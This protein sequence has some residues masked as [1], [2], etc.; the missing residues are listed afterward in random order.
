M[1]FGGGS[2]R[3]CSVS[4]PETKR[5]RTGYPPTGI[6]MAG[7]LVLQP[8]QRVWSKAGRIVSLMALPWGLLVMALAT[9]IW[10]SIA[11]HTVLRLGLVAVALTPAALWFV[12]GFMQRRGM[13][14]FFMRAQPEIRLHHDAIELALGDGEQRRWLPWS[15]IGSLGV[16]WPQLGGTPLCDETGHTIVVIPH[17]LFYLKDPSGANTTLAQEVVRWRP[18]RYMF[19]EASW[20]PM[21][22][23]FQ[24]RGSTTRPS[25]V[26]DDATRSMRLRLTALAVAVLFAVLSFVVWLLRP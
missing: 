26:A 12:G 1:D 6:P 2:P 22:W 10:S 23:G 15:R 8:R 16:T 14:W 13:D 24:L 18:D 11:P 7:G 25:K 9:P 4:R 19:D 3:R 20:V 21:S 17:F 5:A